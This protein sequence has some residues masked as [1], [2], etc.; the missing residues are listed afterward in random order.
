MSW[1]A[2]ALAIAPW[3]AIL[4]AMRDTHRAANRAEAAAR[5]AQAAARAAARAAAGQQPVTEEQ[6]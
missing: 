4:W 2:Y 5:R 1:A 6:P 3:L